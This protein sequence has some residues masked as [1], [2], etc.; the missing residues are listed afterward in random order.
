MSEELYLSIVVWT[1]FSGGARGVM[2]GRTGS[3]KPSV[4]HLKLLVWPFILGKAASD[5]MVFPSET[6]FTKE[7]NGVGL[8]FELP[9][10]IK[11]LRLC[12]RFFA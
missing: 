2:L 10:A 3:E 8:D 12:D 9:E 5:C 6:V 1:L 7:G 11:L 4:G